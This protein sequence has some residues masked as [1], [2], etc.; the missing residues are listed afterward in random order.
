MIRLKIQAYL[1]EK[2]CKQEYS[3]EALF[4]YNLNAKGIIILPYDHKQFIYLHLWEKIIPY[5]NTLGKAIPNH[6]T[7]W[8][9]IIPT[10]NTI[11]QK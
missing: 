5:Y 9:I 6:Y 10:H 3:K 4:W 2:Y 11:W 8:E 1:F 7:F